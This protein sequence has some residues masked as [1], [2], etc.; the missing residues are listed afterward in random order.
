[1]LSTLSARG[2]AT[3]LVFEG[4]AALRTGDPERVSQI[5]RDVSVTVCIALRFA[6]LPTLSRL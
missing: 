4:V 1:M 3:E 5:L 2:Y 6:A